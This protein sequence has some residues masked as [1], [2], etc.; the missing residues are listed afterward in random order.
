MPRFVFDTN[1]LIN[2]I[3]G[4]D[5][6]AYEALRVAAELGKVFISQV[7]ILEMWAPGTWK[8]KED[9]PDV[10]QRWR[11]NLDE[12]E[13]P[14]DMLK[15]LVEQLDEHEQ[16]IPNELAPNMLREGHR[17]DISD[18]NGQSVFLIEYTGDSLVFRSP[19]IRKSQV[20]QEISA[21]KNVC[22]MIGAQ[23]IPVSTRAQSYAEI[24]VQYY[25]DTLG[26]S[27]ILDSL[28]IAAGLVRRAWLVTDDNKW[29]RIAQDIQNKGLPLPK[30]KVI[31]PAR[32]ARAGVPT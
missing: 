17:W 31:D 20:E 26:K 29:N 27:V 18:E 15:V 32:L 12:G 1:V 13:I 7:S 6:D 8:I 4:G 10:V 9:S 19:D 16:P 21:L 11:H 30:M 28:I 23:I 22:G 5:Q 2:H 24:I 3:R 25:R 14:D